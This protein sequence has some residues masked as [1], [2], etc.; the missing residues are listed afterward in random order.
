VTRVFQ[1][2][3]DRKVIKGSKVT[4]D[5]LAPTV[6]LA[7]QG[8]QVR[9]LYMVSRGHLD[10]LEQRESQGKASGDLQGLQV[11]QGLAWPLGTTVA[12]ARDPWDLQ[13]RLDC[14][15]PLGNL[16]FQGKATVLEENPDPQAYQGP[17]GTGDSTVFLDWT[18]VL[19]PLDEMANPD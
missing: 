18:G 5:P 1:G 4:V 14:Q 16:D 6:F 19:E 10:Y 3:L 12:V 11:S 17:R 2:Y 7:P 8:M 15:G 13:A 9:R